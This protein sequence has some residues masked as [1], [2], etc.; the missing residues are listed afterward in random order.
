MKRLF[1]AIL[2]SLCLIACKDPAGA[3][4]KAAADIA[5]GI[6]SGMQTVASLGQS[7]AIT[8]AEEGRVLDYLEFANKGDEAFISCIA[9]AQTAGSKTGTYTACATAFNTTLNNPT[10]LAL[11]KVANPTASQTITTIV[12]GVNVAVTAIVSG[13]GGA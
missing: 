9:A 1:P 5:T 12:N 10:E 3:S 8:P 13:L 4:A 6:N 11:I 7:G 2:F